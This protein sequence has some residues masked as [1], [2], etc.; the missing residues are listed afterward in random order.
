[1]CTRTVLIYHKDG[2]LGL[3]I[4]S[5]TNVKMHPIRPPQMRGCTVIFVLVSLYEI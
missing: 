2:H 3:Y 4:D 1:M 5:V